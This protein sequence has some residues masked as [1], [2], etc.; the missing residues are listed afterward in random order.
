MTFPCTRGSM[1]KFFPVSFE[2]ASMTV[3]ISAFSKFQ[4]G[5]EGSVFS[6]FSDVIFDVFCTD[7]VGKV[8]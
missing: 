8:C 3:R 7:E 6:F 2:T 1:T 5:E 4:I